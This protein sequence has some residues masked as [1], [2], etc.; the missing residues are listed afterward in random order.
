MLKETEKKYVAEKQKTSTE[1]IFP[2]LTLSTLQTFQAERLCITTP[3]AGTQ[4]MTRPPPPT[5]LN[6][7]CWCL[8]LLSITLYEEAY[9]LQ[10][11]SE[12]QCY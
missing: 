12:V 10:Y 1:I 11:Q 4:K 9:E 7:P 2:S 8:A 5:L 6:I 3:S